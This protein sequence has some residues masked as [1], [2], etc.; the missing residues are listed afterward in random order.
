M[1]NVTGSIRGGVTRRYD[2][3]YKRHIKSSVSGRTSSWLA[4]RQNLLWKREKLVTGSIH[5]W[6]SL[7]DRSSLTKMKKRSLMTGSTRY[8]LRYVTGFL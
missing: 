5:M 3:H 7:Y 1:W 2:R 8:G 4:T 6:A